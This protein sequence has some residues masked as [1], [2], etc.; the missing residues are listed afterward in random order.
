MK[1]RAA[2]PLLLFVALLRPS[3]ASAE[4]PEAAGH[5]DA[6][7]PATPAAH[8]ARETPAT[9]PAPAAA[10]TA[11]VAAEERAS[12]MRIGD[13]KLASGDGASALLAYRQVARATDD[14]TESARALLGIARAYRLSGDGVKAAATYEHLIKNHPDFPEIPAALL[15]SGRTLRD[16]GSP[17][18]AIARF[19]SVIHSTLK[20]PE[21][22][23]E[24]YRRIVRTAQFEIAETHLADG[25]YTE[26]ARFFKR[27]D[28]LDLAPADRARARFKAAVCLLRAGEHTSAIAALTVF[29]G[30]DPDDPHS[31]E[32]RFLLAQVLGENGRR[33]ESL[34]V[35]LDLLHYERARAD[36][37]GNWRAW[38]R[39]T[40]NQLA[41]QLYQ[42]G[43]FTSALLVYRALDGLD[44]T[45]AWR[46]P[47]LY[48]LG[49]CQERLEQPT[50]AIATYA[51][52]VK[53][54]GDPPPAD[55]ADIVRMATWRSSQLSWAVA[56][57]EQIQALRPATPP[58]AIT[59]P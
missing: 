2:L 56:T 57:R 1:S 35:T 23:T 34:R 30:Q 21:A 15:E 53:L 24:R 37:S 20:L 13:A 17:K 7:P 58:L 31:P 14:E 49:L 55:L 26:A 32:A 54:A 48:Q 16:L 11:D 43:E 28:L 52:I 38:Q 42:Q 8:E 27:L 6:H 19:Y 59:H 50:E 46:L 25:N 45:P 12:L 51:Q 22:E 18:L 9:K 3:V 39:R 41:N 40:G 36:Q 29:I 5:A 47:V 10:A 33:D 44:T 4:A